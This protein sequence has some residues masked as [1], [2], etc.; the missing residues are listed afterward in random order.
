VRGAG[1]RAG[2]EAGAGLPSFLY[3]HLNRSFLIGVGLWV[4]ACWSHALFLCLLSTCGPPLAARELLSTS[5]EAFEVGFFGL[6]DASLDERV[7]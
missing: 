2:L 6:L 5:M 4:G 3:N 1:A 7:Q